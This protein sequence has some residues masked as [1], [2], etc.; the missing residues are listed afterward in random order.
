[1]SADE[2]EKMETTSA[3]S[4]ST[5]R[6]IAEAQAARK[7]AGTDQ[8][9]EKGLSEPATAANDGELPLERD[10]DGVAIENGIP[11]VRLRGPDDPDRKAFLSRLL[12]RTF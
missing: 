1:M 6:T 12:S 8:D 5:H 2:L 7:E 3:D 10:E 11:I 4:T 9:V